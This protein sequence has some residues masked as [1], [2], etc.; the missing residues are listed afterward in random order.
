MRHSG[1]SKLTTL[2]LVVTYDD[3]Q[4]VLGTLETCF[5]DYSTDQRGD[6][7]SWVRTAAMELI[8]FLLPLIAKLDAEDD[9]LSPYLLTSSVTN[10]IAA[11]LKQ[12]V[13]RIDK[14]RASAGKVL[15]DL[16]LSSESLVIL[17]QDC[18]KE[19]IKR[20]RYKFQELKWMEG[21]KMSI[22]E[23]II[24]A[25]LIEIYLGPHP[26]IYTPLWSKYCK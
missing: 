11:L 23:Q 13:E 3:F 8:N 12:S 6:V 24:I 4:L 26:L 17:G 14:V 21:V 5:T 10:I 1:F 9:Q 15:C 16:V 19:H 2:L 18:L 7:G 20:Y 25:L 22:A